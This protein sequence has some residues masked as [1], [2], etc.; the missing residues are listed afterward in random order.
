MGMATSIGW[1]LGPGEQEWTPEDTVEI[2]ML[3][4][5]AA[6]EPYRA[7][8]LDE[9]LSVPAGL[10][11]EHKVFA[12]RVRGR[13]MIDEGIHDGDYLIVE[14]RQ[15]AE[16]GQTVVAEVDGCVT[17]KKLYRDPDGRIRLQPANPEMLP[18]VLRGDH[19][20]VRGVVVG[21]LRK[22]G[23]ASRQPARPTAPARPAKVEPED[24]TLDLAVNALDA[25]L[26]R[27]SATI[28]AAR[29]QRPMRRQLPAM[30]E[31]GRDLQSIRD[32]CARTTKP[33][34]RRALVAEAN[35]IMRRMQ[36]LTGGVTAERPIETLH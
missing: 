13:S 5:V 33:S 14:P 11:D 23:F 29:R 16:N 3:G 15:R 20:Q 30:E 17:V 21:V 9:S 32:W 18:L 22:Y 4:F 31:L 1:E 19:V 27:W 7:F 8:E 2:P 36:R 28:E 26:A 25:Q 6:G 10:W 34:L 35:R 12:L 24:Q